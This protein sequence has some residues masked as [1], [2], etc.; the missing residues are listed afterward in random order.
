MSNYTAPLR[1]SEQFSET[2]VMSKH[3]H[4]TVT[5]QGVQLSCHWDRQT[6]RH[7]D[8]RHSTV[9]RVQEKGATAHYMKLIHFV[10]CGQKNF[11]NRPHSHIVTPHWMNGC[12]RPSAYLIP[13]P[14]GSHK[15]TLW[16]ISRLVQPVCRT[17]ESD[18]HTNTDR[19]TDHAAPSV[20]I[21]RYRWL[22]LKKKQKRV[23]AVSPVQRCAAPSPHQPALSC[24][25]L[26]SL[27]RTCWLAAFS[28]H[29][30]PA[31]QSSSSL[32]KQ[33]SETT[34]SLKKLKTSTF[35]TLKS[36][37]CCQLLRFST[38]SGNPRSFL[39][40]RLLHGL[41]MSSRPRWRRGVVVTS[42]VVST[43]LLYVERG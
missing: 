19:Q 31:S 4:S 6:D 25:A 37:H 42:L 18:R 24:V 17:H 36:A 12:V 26:P 28:P 9:H 2:T 23:L 20:A 16:T 33:R 3:V 5:L 11:D 30:L 14:L 27:V 43:K 15:L 10:T 38:L 34:I 8:S 1:L 40:N 41:P 35:V 22:S 32:N 29:L 7:T 13:G 21:G 39:I